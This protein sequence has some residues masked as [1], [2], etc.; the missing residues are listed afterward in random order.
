ME[1]PLALDLA[2]PEDLEARRTAEQEG[3]PFLVM[4]DDANAQRICP[5]DDSAGSL[6][7]GRRDEADVAL[8]W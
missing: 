6:T 1:T 2:T 3:R 7:L 4:R 5:L 8:A